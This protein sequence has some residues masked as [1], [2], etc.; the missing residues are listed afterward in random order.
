MQE[1]KLKGYSGCGVTVGNIDTDE[2]YVLKI[3]PGVSYN[4]R[5]FKQKEKQETYQSKRGEIKTPRIISDG[6]LES[7]YF[8]KMDYVIGG[9]TLYEYVDF[10]PLHKSRSVLEI[11]IDDCLS[12]D[13]F[14]CK[15]SV[16]VIKKKIIDQKNLC[17]NMRRSK[18]V[19]D[20]LENFDFSE[21]PNTNCH[22]DLT[23]ENVLISKDGIYYIDFL[24]SFYDSWMM[25]IAKILQDLELL[26]SGRFSSIST[27]AKLKFLFLAGYTR[28][29]IMQL[30]DGS[31]KLDMVYKLLLLNLT[32][33]YP[34]IKD[35]LTMMWLNNSINYLLDK[36][37]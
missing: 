2:P 36:E 9:V 35:D 4:S 13:C 20:I 26:W 28:E 17:L 15:C 6:Y 21:I 23:L 5:L 3:S 1:R 8:F 33:I 11:L 34:Y 14:L 27:E 37:N 32:R 19:F 7:R 10:N 31:R 30:S 24:D 18:E 12:K 16:D 25:D 22:G 29:R